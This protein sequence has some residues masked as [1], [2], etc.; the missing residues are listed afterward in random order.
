MSKKDA[1]LRYITNEIAGIN[2]ILDTQIYPALDL[3]DIEEG[4]DAIDLDTAERL[5]PIYIHALTVLGNI[6]NELRHN[7]ETK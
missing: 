3:Q 1:L 7:N 4:M 5:E 2:E 6:K